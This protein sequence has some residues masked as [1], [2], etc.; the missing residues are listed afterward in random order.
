MTL[1]KSA[2]NK[3]IKR[4]ADAL[5]KHATSTEKSPLQRLPAETNTPEIAQIQRVIQSPPIT[6]STNP[7]AKAILQT[8]KQ[9]HLRITQNNKPGAVPLIPVHEKPT[10]RSPRL[11]PVQYTQSSR[12]LSPPNRMHRVYHIL[13][14]PTLFPKKQSI[15]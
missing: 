11:N 12:L 10:R 5:H 9:T 1:P 15:L 8:K 4:M 6:T 13:I 7:T 14:T 2:K 3:L